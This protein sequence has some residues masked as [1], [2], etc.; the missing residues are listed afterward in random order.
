[1]GGFKNNKL[2]WP[3]PH[4]AFTACLSRVAAIK[5]MKKLLLGILGAI[6]F[7]VERLEEKDVLDLMK[8]RTAMEQLIGSYW[9]MEHLRVIPMARK[10]GPRLRVENQAEQTQNV[11]IIYATV[12]TWRRTYQTY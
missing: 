7:L 8:V 3:H 10:F 2:P 5:E 4:L 1:M 11:Y 6:G 12:C 9:Q